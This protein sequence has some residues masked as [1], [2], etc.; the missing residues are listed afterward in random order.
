M[1]QNAADFPQK[2]RNFMMFFAKTKKDIKKAAPQA[3]GAALKK[4]K[5]YQAN[6]MFAFLF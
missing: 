1:E 5:K 2:M 6:F 3:I 4:M